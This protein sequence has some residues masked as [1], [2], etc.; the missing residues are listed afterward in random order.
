MFTNR[1]YSGIVGEAICKRIITETGIENVAIIGKETI[2]DLYLNGNKSLVKLYGLDKLHI[3]FG[4][5]DEEIKDII[6]EFRNQL[7]NI[8]AELINKIDRVKYDFN[9]IALV[10]KNKLNKLGDDYFTNVILSRS[11]PDFDNIQSFLENPINED[12][13]EQYFDIA[14]ELGQIITIKRGNFDAFEE[15]FLYIY[16]LICDGQSSIKGNK[17]HVLTLLHYMYFECLIGMK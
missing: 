3:P 5:S 13:K 9:R 6:V 4:F 11:L 17:R 10:E 12:L 8:K 7:P 2:N 1:K 16:Q 14:C 15:I